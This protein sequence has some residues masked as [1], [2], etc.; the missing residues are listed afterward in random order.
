MDH[1]DKKAVNHDVTKKEICGQFTDMELRNF[2][3]SGDMNCFTCLIQIKHGEMI[4]SIVKRILFRYDNSD[5]RM[6]RQN[7]GWDDPNSI[8]SEIY[9]HLRKNDWVVLKSWDSNYPFK[10]WLY[11]VATH[12]SYSIYGNI[13]KEYDRIINSVSIREL[14]DRLVV[15][16]D[17]TDRINFFHILNEYK[18]ENPDCYNMIIQFYYERKSTKK[19]SEELGTSD[20]VIRKRKERCINYLLQNL[21]I[22]GYTIADFR[23]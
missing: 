11:T 16:P 22:R 19:I 12:I 9:T 20:D 21:K 18:K 5:W 23:Y 6:A 2:I 4:I 14:T 7:L 10:P 3:I 1:I 15:H 8:F 17:I 13:K